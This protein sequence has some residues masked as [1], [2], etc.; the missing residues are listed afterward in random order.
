MEMQRER[1]AHNTYLHIALFSYLHIDPLNPPISPKL[2]QWMPELSGV[3]SRLTKIMKVTRTTA[4]N[5]NNIDNNNNKSH[6]DL[7]HRNKQRS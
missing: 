2:T 7:M 6:H 4:K 5:D 3:I 1:N